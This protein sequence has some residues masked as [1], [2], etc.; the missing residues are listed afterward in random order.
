[1]FQLLARVMDMQ[2]QGR[3]I[4]RF[5]IGD[6]TIT[7]HQHVI[8]A[9]KR[10]LDERHVGYANSQGIPELRE[11]ICEHTSSSLGFRPAPEQV[12][13]MPA[14]AIIDSV[15]RC[16]MDTG[17]HVVS[18]DPGFVTYQAVFNYTGVRKIP[19]PQHERNHRFRIDPKEL[20]SIVTPETRLIINNSPNNPTGMA[21]DKADI[22]AVYRVAEKHDVYLLNDEIYSR[23]SY[24]KPHASPG[25]YDQCK[26]RT[27]ILNGFSKGYCMSGWR[28]G[29][30]IGPVDVIRKMTL[31]FETIYSCLP[32]FSQYGALSAL[33]EN[34]EIIEEYA[35]TLK[36]LR[37]LTVEKLN[38]LPG[39]TCP[40]PEGAIYAFA[41]ITE[42]GLTS[43]QFQDHML[44]KANVAVLDGSTFGPMGEGYVRL[45]F[46]RKEETIIEGCAR[47]RAFLKKQ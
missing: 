41:N 37:D 28:V 14:N 3:D 30:A 13:I 21:M 31:L 22:E 4:V 45:C 9:T 35:K 23:L 39:V 44:E 1:M 43:K 5:E 46:A 2:R 20:D 10:A 8:D 38:E 24:D 26:E 27:I 29:Y 36:T 40:V 11:A 12:L 19:L 6:S 42:T 33:T 47:M 32:P 16:V 7:V 15:V 18:P 17:E 25:I 34:Q